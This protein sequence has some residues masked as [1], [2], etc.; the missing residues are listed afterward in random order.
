MKTLSAIV[1]LLV[2]YVPARQCMSQTGGDS[3]SPSAEHIVEAELISFGEGGLRVRSAAGE[4]EL[5]PLDDLQAYRLMNGKL[6]VKHISGKVMALP[7]EA[8]GDSTALKEGQW[9]M[10]S[11]EGVDAQYVDV[12]VVGR[13]D[14][15][16]RLRTLDGKHEYE[17]SELIAYR[18]KGGRV[19]IR[20]ESGIVLVTPLEIADK[21]VPTT[22]GK[23]R[24]ISG[25]NSA[26]REA[27]FPGS[28]RRRAAA[29]SFAK[30]WE[31]AFGKL[32]DEIPT[33]LI[34]LGLACLVVDIAFL[35]CF[36]LVICAMFLNGEI[37]TGLVCIAFT[38]VV[39]GGPI[40]GLYYGWR[41]CQAW[42]IQKL[43]IVW[44]VLWVI[45]IALNIILW[46]T[47]PDLLMQM[48]PRFAGGRA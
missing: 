29:S 8:L 40:M 24:N 42:R 41:N 14:N 25:E 15:E 46:I 38:C 1:I 30:E 32:P 20:H 9:N 34:A 18:V 33:G 48:D 19:Q 3:A 17:I 5:F 13:D 11:L 35:I 16:L 28:R 37:T 31:K 45:G 23:W 39:G 44:S 22:G 12:E 4:E 21:A 26:R 7:P 10:L 36:G 43:M 27:L 2:L 6:E 47:L